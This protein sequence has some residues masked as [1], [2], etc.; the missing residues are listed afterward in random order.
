MVTVTATVNEKKKTIYYI[1]KNRKA[2]LDSIITENR[3]INSSKLFV[4]DALSI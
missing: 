3:K 1:I 2:T 4:G